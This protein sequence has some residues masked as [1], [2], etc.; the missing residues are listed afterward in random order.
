[1]NSEITVGFFSGHYSYCIPLRNDENKTIFVVE[2]VAKENVEKFDEKELE[3]I[4]TVQYV[5]HKC[6]EELIGEHFLGEVNH[7]YGKLDRINSCF[8]QKRI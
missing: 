4:E 5:L 8:C 7:F 6:Q 3:Q 2:L 1:M